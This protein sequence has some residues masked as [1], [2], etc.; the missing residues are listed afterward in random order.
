VSEKNKA[1]A[2]RFHLIFQ[3]G[4]FVVADEIIA[5]D[6]VMHAPGL[7]PEMPPG[8]EGAKQYATIV[9]A[10][11]PDHFEIT[12][13]DIMAEGDK[14]VI[15]WTARG[16]HTGEFM[17]I[18]PTGKQI[19]I[20]GMD[21]FRIAGGKLVELWQSWDQLGMLQQLGVVPSPDQGAG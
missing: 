8:P 11:F 4:N 15:R 21:I 19:M 20:T 6:F 10:G 17:G 9:R 12:H 1:V 3:E 13:E 16:T 5:P 18:P 14:V 7:P 2:D